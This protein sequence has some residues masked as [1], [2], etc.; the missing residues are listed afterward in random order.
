MGIYYNMKKSL[1]RAIV[2]LSINSLAG[3]I[4]TSFPPSA[5]ANSTFYRSD[6]GKL[7]QFKN[8]AWV[9]IDIDY[10]FVDLDLHAT[11]QNLPSNNLLVSRGCGLRVDEHFVTFDVSIGV[12]MLND[13]NLVEHDLTMDKVVD[14]F[15]PTKTF[16]IYNMDN[17]TVIGKF[18][19]LN[20][21]EILPMIKADQRPIQFLGVTL[22]SNIT[23]NLVSQ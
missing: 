4:G 13:T 16:P 3:G 23:A 18:Q 6:Q 2:E 1:I 11:E 19:V 15:L 9:E 17:G 5:G 7:Y 20:D 8:S 10:F 12:M 22:A 14:F 21:I